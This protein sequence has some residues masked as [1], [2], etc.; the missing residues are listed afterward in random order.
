MAKKPGKIYR[1]TD[2][3]SYTRKEYL[4]GIPASKITIYDMGEPKEDFEVEVSLAVKEDVQITHNALEAARVSA[5][6]YLHKTVGTVGYHFK[7][8]VHPHQIL[9][10]NKMASGAGADRVSQ[11]MSLSFG[12]AV[13][14]AARV[15]KGQ[16]V[17]T[18][19]TSKNN[20]QAAKT[21]LKR[22]AMKIP[23]GSSI[24]VDKGKELLDL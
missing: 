12:K 7:V 6:R 9:R 24:I 3:R 21:A 15:K 13:G 20:F 1:Q 14:R 4:G 8:R 22:T 17:F 2:K 16:R 10:E 19:R 23:C 18:V 11:G 5:N